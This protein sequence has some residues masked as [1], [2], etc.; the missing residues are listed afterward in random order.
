[1]MNLHMC[2]SETLVNDMVRAKRELRNLFVFLNNQVLKIHNRKQDLKEQQ[3]EEQEQPPER[4]EISNS[5][6]DL[7]KLNANLG[8]LHET[9]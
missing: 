3:E 2:M 9:V 8:I 6:N 1:M 4:E 7:A 5:K